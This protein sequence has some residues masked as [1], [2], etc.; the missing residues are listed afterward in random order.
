MGS[1][2]Y[3]L[4]LYSIQLLFCSCCIAPYLCR[5]YKRFNHFC[6]DVHE[7]VRI[8]QR[9]SSLDCWGWSYF[10]S[11]YKSFYFTNY[12]YSRYVLVWDHLDYK[13]KSDSRTRFDK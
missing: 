7:W 5:S 1:F 2:L 12:Y 9:F 8:L 6:C 11:L 4:I 10:N 3:I 13:I